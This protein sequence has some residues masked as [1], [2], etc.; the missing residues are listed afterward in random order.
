[1]RIVGDEGDELDGDDGVEGGDVPL[2]DGVEGDDVGVGGEADDGVVERHADEGDGARVEGDVGE[3]V[4]EVFGV[5][6]AAE[7]VAGLFDA[8]DDVG[9]EEDGVDGGGLG[10]VEGVHEVV[11][12]AGGEAVELI[13]SI[14]WECAIDC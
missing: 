2:D 7:E 1:M 5:E 6:L 9:R 8:A 13:E 14:V 4:E 3:E 12:E 10:D 11:E